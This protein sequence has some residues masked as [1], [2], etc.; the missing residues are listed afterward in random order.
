M[1][2]MKAREQRTIEEII[3]KIPEQIRYAKTK[4]ERLRRIADFPDDASVLDVGAAHGVFVAA[5]QKL[6]YRGHGI[7]PWNEARA[8]AA[9]LSAYL[10][11]PISI[12]EGVAEEIP[13]GNDSFDIVHA[14]SVIEHVLDLDASFLEI[15]R[16]LKPGGVFWFNVA[17]SMCP[18]QSEIA[19]FPLFGWYPGPIKL[20]IMYW[21]KEYRPELV[22]YTERPAIHWFTP[23]K[24]RRILKEHGFRK[25]YDRWDI[26][27]ENECEGIYKHMLKFIRMSKF[28]KIIADVV[29]P[30]SN[31]AAIK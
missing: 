28:S 15:F 2:E 31:Y 20:K 9:Q 25:V 29:I 18:V 12:V 22:G 6:G 13:F 7:E 1:K 11:V 30:G 8:N 16:V 26:R 24:A 19:G 21:A 4:F 17:S 23:W 27:G 10:S 3:P 5:C 14:N